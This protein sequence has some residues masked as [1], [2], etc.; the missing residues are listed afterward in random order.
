MH[1]CVQGMKYYSGTGNCYQGQPWRKSTTSFWSL[2]LSLKWSWWC[3]GLLGKSEIKHTTVSVT[4]WQWWEMQPF[5]YKS[6]SWRRLWLRVGWPQIR[7]SQGHLFVFW[8]RWCCS[9]QNIKNNQPLPTA[10]D[11]QVLEQDISILSPF[12]KA[13]LLT[14]RMA[15]VELLLSKSCWL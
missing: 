4:F 15:K 3:P 12:K 13:L 14:F 9:I 8:L 11:C 2:K 5:R 10:G 7:R 6:I 1:V